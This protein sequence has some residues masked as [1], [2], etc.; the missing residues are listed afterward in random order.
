MSPRRS[1]S[2]E[3]LCRFAF[4][5]GRRCTQSAHPDC[6]G[7][8]YTHGT[9]APRASRQ[10]NLLRE[11]APL[12]NG[13]SSRKARNRALRALSRAVAAQRISPERAAVLT[14]IASLIENTGRFADT[15]SFRKQSGPAWD[16]LRALLDRD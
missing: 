15:E 1:D 3:T 13:S 6:D 14:H 10:D 2:P 7:L 16:R 9:L 8:C 4:A 5:D 12:A 11:L